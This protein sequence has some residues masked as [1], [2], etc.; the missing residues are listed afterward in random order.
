MRLSP[1]T[2]LKALAAL[3]LVGLPTTANETYNRIASGTVLIL[4]NNGWGSG[5]LIDADKRLVVTAEHVV[6]YAI[7][8]GSNRIKVIFPQRNDEGRIITDGIYYRKRA[9]LL[10]IPGTII[11]SSHAKDLALI[12]IDQVPKEARPIPLAPQDPTPGDRVHLVGNSTLIDG[13]AF[14]YST[15][16][17]RNQY[18]YDRSDFLYLN[19]PVFR[20][21]TRTFF[22]LGHHAPANQ[23]DS[24]GPVVTD[25]GELVGINSSISIGKEQAIGHSVH[26]RE[27]KSSLDPVVQPQTDFF[28]IEATVDSLGLDTFLLPVKKEVFMSMKIK[29][30]GQTDLDLFAKDPDVVK[31]IDQK[32]NLIDYE[33]FVIGDGLTDGESGQFNPDWSGTVLVQVLNLGQPKQSPTKVLTPKNVYTLTVEWKEKISGPVTLIRR[34]ADQGTDKVQ[35]HYPAGKGKARLRIRGDGDTDL[36]V[37]VVDPQGRQVA[38]GNPKTDH[39]EISWQPTLTGTYTVK[40]V[41]QGKI[42]NQYVLTTD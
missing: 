6:K 32:K 11:Y 22:A 27:I 33:R 20:M 21:K 18:P 19:M 29:G 13:G 5:V 31:V 35:L 23:G 3:L 14:G 24:G 28:T 36:N 26:A 9:D 1:S 2:S 38:Q 7:R 15:G 8:N 16:H 37:T 34:I 4:Q 39:H 10:G 41:N 30:T 17:V 25:K 12:Q 40:I 42:W